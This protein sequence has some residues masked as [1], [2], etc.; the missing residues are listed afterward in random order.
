MPKDAAVELMDFNPLLEALPEGFSGPQEN[1]RVKER[2]KPY[3]SIGFYRDLD[4]P[5]GSQMRYYLYEDRHKPKEYIKDHTYTSLID[6]EVAL[7]TDADKKDIFRNNPKLFIMGHGGDDRYGVGGDHPARVEYK[8]FLEDPRIPTDP[9]EQIHGA[10]FDK[11]INDLRD[12]VTHKPGELSITLEICNSDNL[13][14]GKQL[15]G[16]KKTFLASVSETHKDI[17]FSGTGP[18]DTSHSWAAVTTGNRA[19]A[20]A[21]NTPV[22]SMGGSVWKH[23]NTVI[24]HH[25]FE[26]GEDTGFYQMILKKPKF[27]S[28]ETAKELKINTVNY[29]A[30]ILE[31]APL[32]L[33]AK[34]RMLQEISE[35]PGIL[36]IEDLKQ[37]DE[38][39]GEAFR[40]VEAA[41]LVQTE[42][43]ILTREKERYI[44]RVQTILDKGDAVN[45]RDIL[46]LALGLKDYAE[47][48][49]IEGS[50]FEGHQEVLD[51]ILANPKLL[52]LVM[53]TSGKVLI[54][55]PNNDSLIDLLQSKGVSV[56]SVDGHGMTALH[57]AVQN[58][59]VYRAEP[60]HLVKKLL[61]CGANV[62]LADNAG[63]TPRGLA[64]AHGSKGMVMGG[65]Q[66]KE[67]I[68]APSASF[69]SASASEDA[70]V[71]ARD[72]MQSF[73]SSIPSDPQT[74]ITQEGTE[75]NDDSITPTN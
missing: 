54:A 50:V 65:Q 35:N 23:G 29:A 66:L 68:T 1:R 45:D 46:V 10:N 3:I 17:T 16:H 31:N 33:S 58:F 74:G 21:L 55:S 20:D 30:S 56:N 72:I 2:F 24:F 59:Y 73:K 57:Y 75:E 34:K 5:E 44:Q 6:L 7:Q 12:V 39:P 38:F 18:W 61:D 11:I 14:L 36:K 22:T 40:T 28:T 64:M 8:H 25:Q 51:S 53:V 15:W 49:S 70:L 26:M 9:S 63:L 67:L 71:Q 52:E 60:L 19:G 4:M 13:F 62:E 27:S 69:S 43:D 48:G 37:I 41:A 32:G 42:N 47:K